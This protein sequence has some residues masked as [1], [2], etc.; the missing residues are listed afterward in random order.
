M[1]PVKKTFEARKN[2]MKKI[3]GRS[4]LSVDTPP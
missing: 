2:S 3:E 1:Q 4:V